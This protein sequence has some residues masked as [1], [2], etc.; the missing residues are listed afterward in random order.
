[1][2]I[3][4]ATYTLA[5][6]NPAGG[7]RILEELRR[8][9]QVRGHEVGIHDP[10]ETRVSDW[11]LVHYFTMIE[12]SSWAYFKGRNYERKLVVTPAFSR[13]P[14]SR[15][16]VFPKTVGRG[17]LDPA[18]RTS[19]PDHWIA[20]TETERSRL[21]R[22]M[23]IAPSRTS[24]IPGGV[25]PIFAEGD[26]ELFR[27]KYGLPEPFILHVGRF[28]PVKNH[29]FLAE[30]ARQAKVTLVCIGEP[31]MDRIPYFEQSARAIA[32][33]GG[34]VIRGLA[35]GDPL[36]RAA[37]AAASAF[38]LPSENETFGLAALEA[39]VSGTPLILS[40]GMQAREV[41][42]GPRTAWLPSH[43]LEAWVQAMRKAAKT[44]RPAVKPERAKELLQRYSWAQVAAKTEALYQTLLG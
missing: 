3:L 1:M 44:P 40:A 22:F 7:T 18:W 17:R 20:S 5:S 11:D 38:A 29:P 28:H 23:G 6:Q 24:V 42:S 43:D 2:R 21:A 14:G 16:R 15:G 19:L 41:F 39:M 35:H 34:R 37:Y 10:W 33:S 9:L 8:E 32:S 25:N 13:A 26:P 27:K 30:A 12:S 31:E 4:F 36:M